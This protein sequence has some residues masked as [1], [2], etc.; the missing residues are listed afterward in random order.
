MAGAAL[1]AG[2]ARALAAPDH[3]LTI[4]P[5]SLEVS[6][7][8]FIRTTAYNGQSPGPLLRLLEGMP[9]TINVTNRTAASEI[10][11][12]HGLFLPPEV[13]GAAEEGTPP[14]APG[15]SATYTFT[16]EPAG[17][18]WYHTHTM[19]GSDMRRGLYSGQFGV[20]WVEPRVNPAR[21]DEEFF[22][23]LHDWDGTMVGSDDGSMG[24]VYNISTI[25]GRVLG[26]GEPLRVKQGQR[27]M[28]HVVNTSATEPHWLSLAGH[29]FRVIA[30][31][32]NAVPSPRTVTMLHLS[33]AERVSAEVVM[34]NPGVWVLGEVRRHVQAAGMGVVVEYAG[35]GGKPVWQ[36]PQMLEWDYLQFGA[37]RSAEASAEVNVTTIPLVFES[38][39]AGHG[40]MDR[41]MINGKS[42]PDTETVGLKQGQRYR[43]IFRNRSMDD[44]PVHLH[45][46]TFELRKING[47]ETR[48]ILK[49]TVLVS[50]GKEVEVEF[51][52]ERAG[53]SLFHC[54]QQ[55]HMDMGF[56]MLFRCI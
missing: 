1:L 28:L 46:N 40:A 8:R 37:E 12:W 22:L 33:P 2:D 38:K 21:Y 39:F 18:R 15:A 41:W 11:H 45:R 35:S 27:V 23:T 10:V 47:R 32:G 16:P 50:A 30:L 5:C 56:M 17:L 51:T 20:L 54:H 9:V 13:D 24:P 36:Q 43:L 7:R 29:R 53:L 14:I 3:S 48:G 42:Y 6:R 44:H 26:F 19:A 31:D 34:D 49:D 25:N 4:G 52:A 55:D